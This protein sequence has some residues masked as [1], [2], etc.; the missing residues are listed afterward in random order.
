M[1]AA[2]GAMKSSQHDRALHGRSGG[3]PHVRDDHQLLDRRQLRD[4]VAHRA[5]DEIALPLPK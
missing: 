2:C 1:A 4:H 5:S 3:S